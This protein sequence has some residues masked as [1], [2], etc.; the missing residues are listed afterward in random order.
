MITI[1]ITYCVVAYLTEMRV[2]S[3]FVRSL[4]KSVLDL[5]EAHNGGETKTSICYRCKLEHETAINTFCLD[6]KKVKYCSTKCLKYNKPL[7]EILCKIYL[8]NYPII[9]ETMKEMRDNYESVKRIENR[10]NLRKDNKKK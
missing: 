1:N 5:N 3:S 6:C 8:D 9:T 2:L 7:H 10:K 4:I